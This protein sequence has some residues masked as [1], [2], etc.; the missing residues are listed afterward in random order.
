MF[1]PTVMIFVSLKTK[2]EQ[3]EEACHTSPNMFHPLPPWRDSKPAVVPTLR[4]SATHQVPRTD[5]DVQGVVSS[6]GK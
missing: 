3:H 6:H 5:L 1:A 4:E 2:S